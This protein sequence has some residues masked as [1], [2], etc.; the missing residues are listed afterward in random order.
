M[1]CPYCASSEL[2]VLETRDSA[3]GI[4]RRRKCRTCQKRFSTVERLV[5]EQPPMI[6]KRDGRREAFNREKL[7]R[8]IYKACDK[9]PLPVGEIE[10]LVDDIQE[11][12][13]RTNRL[14]APSRM[15]GDMVMD[16]LS[17]LDNIAY[18]RFASV[19]LNPADIT[20]LLAIIERLRHTENENNL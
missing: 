16:R 5:F 7:V 19:Y 13:M 9:R 15:I 12:L 1:Q 3:E 17:K 4:Q 14:E 20:D 6:I 18:V 10:R 8:N 11:E 2:T